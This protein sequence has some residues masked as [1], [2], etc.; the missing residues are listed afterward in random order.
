MVKV[1]LSKSDLTFVQKWSRPPAIHLGVPP[2]FWTGNFMKFSIWM[3]FVAKME[4]GR[5]SR[6]PTELSKMMRMR[7]EKESPLQY[8]LSPGATKE[9]PIGWVAPGNS[10]PGALR[11]RGLVP[12]LQMQ[13]MSRKNSWAWQL[14]PQMSSTIVGRLFWLFDWSWT[15][16]K[17]VGKVCKAEKLKARSSFICHE[18]KH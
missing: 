7:Y 10:S 15:L 18:R 17:K 12:V 5:I 2:K 16:Q 4:S 9:L 3:I 11:P 6:N 1:L 8:S 13:L 14:L